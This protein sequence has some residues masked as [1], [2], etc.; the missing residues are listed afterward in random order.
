MQ[1]LFGRV[2]TYSINAAIAQSIF[3]RSFYKDLQ[4][5]LETHYFTDM[6]LIFFLYTRQFSAI[7]ILVFYTNLVSKFLLGYF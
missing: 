5:V 2:N 3:E 4:I 6:S 7:Y 1:S